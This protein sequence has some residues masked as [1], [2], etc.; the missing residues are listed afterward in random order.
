MKKWMI[1]FALMLAGCS[2]RPV[3]E[4]IGN[5]CQGFADTEPMNIQMW[6]PQEAILEASESNGESRY[7]CGNWEIWT[8]IC[9]GGDLN[10][11][12]ETMSGMDPQYMT[13]MSRKMGEYTCHETVW[14]TT[15]ESGTMI[16][17]GAVLEDGN[18]HY[19]IGLVSSEAESA[20]AKAVFDQILESVSLIGTEN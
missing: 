18:H 13:V 5:A 14:S 2:A 4:T 20:E 10:Q 9:P 12:L 8:V 1:V 3:Y 17:H 15:G 7:I 16:C 11:T 6:L 19:C